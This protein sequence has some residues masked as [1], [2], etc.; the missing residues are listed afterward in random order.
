MSLGLCLFFFNIFCLLLGCKISIVLYSSPWFFFLLCPIC[1]CAHL[2]SFPFLLL[3]SL[4]LNFSFFYSFLFSGTIFHLFTYYLLLLI[5]DVSPI[6]YFNI[7]TPTYLNTFIIYA[8]KYSSTRSKM[9]SHS[10]WVSSVSLFPEQ[11]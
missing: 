3:Y 10:E 7:F 4:S 9:C 5:T 6:N 1:S 2:I 8:L 11:G